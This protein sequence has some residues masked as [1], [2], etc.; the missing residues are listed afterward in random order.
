MKAA[1]LVVFDIPSDKPEPTPRQTERLRTIL[2][3]LVRNNTQPDT[4]TIVFTHN[5]TP[6]EVAALP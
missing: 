3:A 6:A 1:Y 5:L 4:R 2:A